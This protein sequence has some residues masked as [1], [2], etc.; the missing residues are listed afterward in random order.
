MG[1]AT[2][3]D[4]N[5]GLDV[6]WRPLCQEMVVTK[7]CNLEWE[8]GNPEISAV[9]KMS[10]AFSFLYLHRPD[11]TAPAHTRRL[12]VPSHLKRLE[13]EDG[14]ELVQSKISKTPLR[15]PCAHELLALPSRAEVG[16]GSMPVSAARPP[17]LLMRTALQLASTCN[18]A[19]SHTLERLGS[20]GLHTSEP[21]LGFE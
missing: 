13:T 6:R 2:L 17:P 3:V 1:M 15:G 10:R 9:R 20:L 11:P 21:W 7:N 18:L 14:V 4:K 5:A 19:N 16:V 12:Q 8:R